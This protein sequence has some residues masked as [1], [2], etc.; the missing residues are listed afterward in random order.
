MR[1]FVLAMALAVGSAGCD[2]GDPVRPIPLDRFYFPTAV[3]LVH[4]AGATD[5]VLYVANSNFDQRYASGSVLAVSLDALSLPAFGVVPV[6]DVPVIE[7]LRVAADGAVL[8]QSLSGEIAGTAISGGAHR[9]VVPSRGTDHLLHFLDARGAALACVGA[10]DPRDCRPN[11]LSL[12]DVRDEESFRPAGLSPFG[13]GVSPLGQVVVTH[14]DAARRPRGTNEIGDYYVGRFALESP[15]LT[16][17]AFVLINGCQGCAGPGYSVGVGS[18]YAFVT[19]RAGNQRANLLRFVELEPRPDGTRHVASAGLELQ[20][21]LTEARGVALRA[22]QSRL[23]MAI[24][25]T[26][27]FTAVGPSALAVVELSG[28]TGD[29]PSARVVRTVTLPERAANVALIERPGRGDLVLISGT[30]AGVLS[31][32]DDA[33]G[34]VVLNLAGVGKEPFGLAVETRGVGARAYLSDFSDGRVTVV[35]IPNVLQPQGAFIAARLGRSQ[36][37]LVTPENPDCEGSP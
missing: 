17:D 18:R 13:V 11:A 19:G 1:S 7:D 35:D 16:Q 12:E 32:Y 10:D 29:A 34:I 31:L 33:A 8:I 20:F 22:D 28:A 14:F 26:E 4:E 5:G 30:G 2:P 37:C 27:T 21:N 23:Y 3:R 25:A 36:V 9:L 6:D 24:R 15:A